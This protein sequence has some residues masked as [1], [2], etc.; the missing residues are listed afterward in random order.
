MVYVITYE[1]LQIKEVT[2]IEE[3][4]SKF[5]CKHFF[6][7]S[8]EPSH[9]WD[10][11]EVSQHVLMEKFKQISRRVRMILKIPPY[12]EFQV[13]YKRLDVCTRLVDNKLFFPLHF[14][15]GTV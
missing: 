15:L 8:L 6:D 3:Q 11:N 1:L 5:P 9:Q 13:I 14:V 2:I 10:S 4:F 7:P 12:Q